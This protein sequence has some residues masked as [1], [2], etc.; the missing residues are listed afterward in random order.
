MILRTETLEEIVFYY[1]PEHNGQDSFVAVP[2]NIFEEENPVHVDTTMQ[3]PL[4]QDFNLVGI[5]FDN[6]IADA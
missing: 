6:G 5:P 2:R 3:R 4:F 1:P